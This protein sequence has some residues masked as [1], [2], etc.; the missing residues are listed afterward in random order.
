MQTCRLLCAK[1]QMLKL[2]IT[3]NLPCL[4]LRRKAI[5]TQQMWIW[6]N[7]R[8]T[9]LKQCLRRKAATRSKSCLAQA[10]LTCLLHQLALPSKVSVTIASQPVQAEP[11]V[12]DPF[13]LLVV[14]KLACNLRKQQRTSQRFILSELLGRSSM[15]SV[16]SNC[17]KSILKPT[18]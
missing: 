17:P 8:E 14:P 5:K 18:R 15:P 2:K 16:S 9:T 3:L 10:H 12:A 11:Q 6:R 4:E 1:I 13:L 7:R